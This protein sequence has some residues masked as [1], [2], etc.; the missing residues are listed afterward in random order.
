MN[1]EL[2]FSVALFE[3]SQLAP[4]F[5]DY[6]IER[7]QSHRSTFE[8][9]LGDS[10]VLIRTQQRSAPREL[11]RSEKDDNDINDNDFT[12]LPHSDD[13]KFR[14]KENYALQM[15]TPNELNSTNSSV[16]GF[17]RVQSFKKS[18]LFDT[19]LTPNAAQSGYKSMES[20]EMGS[21]EHPKAKTSL[22]FSEPMFSAKSFYG[23]KDD[24]SSVAKTDLPSYMLTNK[25][26]LLYTETAKS[27]A[28]RKNT[29]KST[30]LRGPMLWKH[31]GAIRKI[32]GRA[33]KTVQRK[34]RLEDKWLKSAKGEMGRRLPKDGS[35]EKRRNSDANADAA[36]VRHEQRR[37][38]KKIFEEQTNVVSRP[39][40]WM[41]PGVRIMDHTFGD[42]DSDED[43]IPS[44]LSFNE[45]S[46]NNELNN[47]EE[48]E[49]PNEVKKSRKFFKSSV[50]STAKK[51]RIIG[52]IHAT[53]KRGCDIKL[54][55]P[56]KRIKRARHSGTGFL[57]NE[58]TGIINRLSS[59]QKAKEQVP[60]NTA[61]ALPADPFNEPSA[62]TNEAMDALSGEL[63]DE[64][65]ECRKYI[66]ML[67]YQTDD[68]SKIK[69]QESI[70]E[71]L[72]SNG[73]CNDDT[74]KIFIAEPDLH[75]DEASRILDKLYC[76]TTMMPANDAFADKRASSQ[77]SLSSTSSSPRSK[78]TSV[79]S[80]LDQIEVEPKESDVQ[81]DA[82][83]MPM[84]PASQIS[85]MT[86]S[87]AI[88]EWHHYFGF[89]Y[90]FHS[91]CKLFKNSPY[92]RLYQ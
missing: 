1:I 6:T 36:S 32:R 87:L 66:E 55:R 10:K 42:S 71:L 23:R 85:D 64:Q 51:Y 41:K 89:L 26:P 5:A 27:K 80:G 18:L 72:I 43:E 52:G 57:H 45:T 34:K 91:I 25:L 86:L 13:E 3:S 30:S 11:S 61:V 74:F 83:P 59:P 17:P 21:N 63:H 75:K 53:L 54:D 69:Q 58:I 49:D 24:T 38:L 73:I 12:E 28:R 90:F 48:N 79:S 40:N 29:R 15:K 60:A 35:D 8:N 47:Q 22:Q 67:P 20:N 65:K 4:P 62:T 81:P 50:G 92:H 88:R 68:P 70:L 33:L 14:G 7:N 84:S 31:G 44:T 46:T 37:R 82:Q 16:N 9:I 78:S 76:V 77:H 19:G 39:I 56:V 2:V